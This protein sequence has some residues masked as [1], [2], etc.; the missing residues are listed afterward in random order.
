MMEKRRS[1]FASIEEYVAYLEVKVDDL[2]LKMSAKDRDLCNIQ[3]QCR[4]VN[5]ILDEKDYAIVNL[6]KQN[7]VLRKKYMDACAAIQTNTRYA[8]SY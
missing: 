6:T 5:K 7:S 1:D 8:N 4:E 3:K 2:A